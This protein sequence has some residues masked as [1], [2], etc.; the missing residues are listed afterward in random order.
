MPNIIQKYKE[1]K[2][3]RNPIVVTKAKTFI[4]D[5]LLGIFTERQVDV[6]ELL[7]KGK[8]VR[9]YPLYLVNWERGHQNHD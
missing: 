4:A 8:K 9:K 2:L 3:V 5:R 7:S 6:L 1:R